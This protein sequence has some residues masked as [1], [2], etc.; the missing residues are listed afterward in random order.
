MTPSPIRPTEADASDASDASDAADAPRARTSRSRWL[1][2]EADTDALGADL[3]RAIVHLAQPPHAGMTLYFSG[4]LG[5]GKTTLIRSLLRAL[6]VTGRIKSP[7]Y[8]LVEPYQI[9]LRDGLQQEPPEESAASTAPLHGTNTPTS[10]LE[11]KRNLSLY[12]YHFDFYRFADPR[13][14][15]EAGFR[16]YF[17][18][19][20]LCFVE[21]PEKVEGNSALGGGTLLPPADVRVRLDPEGEGRRASLQAFSERGVLCLGAA[22][23]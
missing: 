6:G 17:S 1:A 18:D 23:F 15:L 19:N 11:L 5:A 2:N 20:S 8:T 21:W 14:F 4:D 12:C 9:V 22:G 3:A 7:T 10:A 13:E 16:E